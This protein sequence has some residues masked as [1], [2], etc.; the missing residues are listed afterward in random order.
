MT[1]VLDVGVAIT[2][3]LKTA[4]TEASC[5]FLSVGGPFAFTLLSQAGRHCYNFILETILSCSCFSKDHGDSNIY[6][7]STTC[8]SCSGPQE[9]KMSKTQ[10]APGKGQ[11]NTQ[12]DKHDARQ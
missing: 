1:G 5:L 3:Q 12:N 2:L 9:A 11:T 8:R 10:G 7:V 4:P 6:E